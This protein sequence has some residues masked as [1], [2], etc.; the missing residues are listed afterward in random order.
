VAA[1]SG[2]TVVPNRLD[3]WSSVWAWCEIAS[4]TT[5][6]AWPRPVTARPERKSRYSRP[7]VSQSRLPSPR[8]KVTGGGG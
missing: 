1:T 6:W 3:T 7:S 8:T 5:G 4:A 2:P